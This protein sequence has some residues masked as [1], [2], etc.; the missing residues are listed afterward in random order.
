[1]VLY[2]YFSFFLIYYFQFIS[3]SDLENDYIN[4]IDMADRMNMLLYP[5]VGLHGFIT[6]LFLFSGYWFEFLF[7]LPLLA[8]YGYL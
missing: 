7:N 5:D 6:V 1:M 2:R 8:Y 3:A 4:P